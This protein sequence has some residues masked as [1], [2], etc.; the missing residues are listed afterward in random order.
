MAKFVKLET[1]KGDELHFNLDYIVGVLESKQMVFPANND[2]VGVI[3][4]TLQ[5]MK[6]LIEEI[7]GKS[8]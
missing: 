2:H 4:I 1:K 6:K 8:K 3:S 5:S 7:E